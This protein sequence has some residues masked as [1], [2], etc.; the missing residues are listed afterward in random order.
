MRS[1]FQI[2]AM[3]CALSMAGIAVAYFPVGPDSQGRTASLK[4]APQITVTPLQNTTGDAVEP[5]GRVYE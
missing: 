5:G 1:F 2:T 3:L 4:M